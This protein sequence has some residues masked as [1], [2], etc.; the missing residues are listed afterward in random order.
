MRK[1]QQKQLLEL[2]ATIYEANNLIKKYIDDKKYEIAIKLLADCQEAAIS[3]G[4]TI[5]KLEGEGTVTVAHLEE[6]CDILYQVGSSLEENADSLKYFKVIKNQIQVIENSI[7]N[8]VKSDR[9][10]IVF[11]PYK[12][13]MWD[14]MESVWQAAKDDPQCDV[15]VIPIP[16]YD[17]N[18]DNSLGRVHYEGDQFPEYVPVTDWNSYNIAERYPDIIY[19]H[20]PYDQ[21]NFVTRVHSNYFSKTLKN[22]TEMLVYIPY[23]VVIEQI[24]EDFC[25]FPGPIYADKVIVQSEEIKNTYIKA[26]DDFERKNNRKGLF[27]DYK[28]KF[29]PLGSP[30]FDKVINT[31]RKD[32]Q[33]P[34]GWAELIKKQGGR[35]KVFLYNTSI[36]GI[37]GGNEK[38][39]EKLKYVLNS[40]KQRNDV[41]LLWRP[42]PLNV[43]TYSSMR[44]KLLD[45]YLKIIEKYKSEGWGI[46]DDT[47]DMNRAIAI[48]DAYYGDWSSLV[49]LYQCT[50]KPIMIQNIELPGNLTDQEKEAIGFYDFIADGDFIWVS[51]INCNA[52]FKINV[53]SMEAEYMGSFPHEDLYGKY[54]HR[55]VIK[56]GN[57]L[58]FTPFSADRIGIYDI[59]TNEFLTTPELK[60]KDIPFK[61]ER[62]IVYG[63]YIFFFPQRYNAIV[64]YNY[65]TNEISYFN[66]WLHEFHEVTAASNPIYFGFGV[67]VKDNK[68]YIPCR[69]TNAILEFDLTEGKSKKI[70]VGS[71]ENTYISILYDSGYFYLISA[72]QSSTIT[73]WNPETG[74]I[75]E[76]KDMPEGFISQGIPFINL[77][78]YGKYILALQNEANMSVLLDTES[79]ETKEYTG[80]AQDDIKKSPYAWHGNYFFAKSLNSSYF[81]AVSKYDNAIVFID[82]NQMN[83]TRRKAFFPIEQSLLLSPLYKNQNIGKVNF[84]SYL[85]YETTPY[86][87]VSFINI[88]EDQDTGIDLIKPE[89]E[90]HES[91]GLKIH[92]TIKGLLQM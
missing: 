1:H 34:E 72:A 22:Y 39:I 44:P 81:L 67:E 62:S 77:I 20:N 31:K 28:D 74:E 30:K 37:L 16:Y 26:F 36:N 69:Q 63:D 3:I 10:E 55:S 24:A 66:D 52:L 86:S 12:A 64:K 53:K 84:E 29:I 13:S 78:K 92:K 58:F 25:I 91:S 43:S 50:R 42:H 40:F 47:A 21:T 54:L 15:Y 18:T 11:L 70:I 45:E 82:K 8:D 17:V 85:G 87:M 80:L 83:V 73:R 5:E 35:K 89:N 14:S 27:G 51:A 19:I 33:L 38:Y 57:K 79:G 7:L 2:V 56:I 75:R 71:D 23:F 46:Y 41:V 88:I 61:F 68:A 32:V 49:A 9:L 60:N 6:F 65:K 59:E 48:S 4:N 76:Y 90:I